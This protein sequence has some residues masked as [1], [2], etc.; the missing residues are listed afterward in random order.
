MSNTFKGSRDVIV[1]T[2]NWS[3]ALKFYGSI[4]GL[5]M[6][7]RGEQEL[8]RLIRSEFNDHFSV[9]HKRNGTRRDSAW[10]EPP[11]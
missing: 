9:F 6:T 5:P 4:L 10:V 3:E 7:D 11:A 2:E 1:R 8:E